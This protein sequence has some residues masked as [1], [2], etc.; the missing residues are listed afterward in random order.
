M[1]AAISLVADLY[2]AA[3]TD[4]RT[5]QRPEGVPQRS[6]TKI[7]VLVATTELRVAWAAPGGG[8]ESITI[9]VIEEDTAATDHNGGVVGPYEIR[10]AGGCSCDKLLK[11]WNPYQGQPVQ[12]VV[13]TTPSRFTEEY[14]LPQR[15]KRG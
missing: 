3:I 4:T 5:G 2:P 9:P 12:Q 13:R 10:R 6:A 7:R 14:G 1:T 15:Y 11:R 8:V